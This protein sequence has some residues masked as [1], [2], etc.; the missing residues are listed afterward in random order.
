MCTSQIHF[1]DRKRKFP[2][3]EKNFEKEDEWVE[4]MTI[5]KRA[6]LLFTFCVLLTTCILIASFANPS[7]YQY[8]PMT[9]EKFCWQAVRHNKS[10]SVMN[11]STASYIDNI[12][13]NGEKLNMQITQQTLTR[14]KTLQKEEKGLALTS[15][16]RVTLGHGF[17][18]QPL[19]D[20]IKKRIYQKSYKENCTI[21]YEDLNYVGILYVDFNGE[22]QMGEIV[23]NKTIAKDLAEIFM[24]LYKN[25]YPLDK[26]RLVDEY[27]AD[28]DLSCLDNNT[29]CFNF[30]TVGGTSRLSKHAEGLAI[31]IN[32]FFNPYVTYPNGSI[33][34]S[35]PGSE[36]YGDRSHDFPHKIDTNDLCYRLFT[37][38]GFT[39][40]GS[41]SSVKDYQHFE[42]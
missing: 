10:S 21:P 36:A 39:W 16:E 31:D 37:M 24:E 4:K 14:L 23:C 22:T 7:G 42:K 28:D 33:R 29:S 3:Y 27:N 13:K 18:Y 17:F 34:I 40:G 32:P 12:I 5:K 8:M 20:D 26:V 30:R 9:S 41:W 2:S 38:H 15:P 19:T 6:F 35:P 11:G 1:Y 25:K